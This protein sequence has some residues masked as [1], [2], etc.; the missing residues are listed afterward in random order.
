MITFYRII[1]QLSWKLPLLLLLYLAFQREHSFSSSYS[2]NSE[3][4]PTER[5][6]ISSDY[7]RNASTEKEQSHV[8]TEEELNKIVR[9][10]IS[11]GKG[12]KSNMSG[13]WN[14]SSHLNLADSFPS[15]ILPSTSIPLFEVPL[16]L[17]ERPLPQ[18][19]PHSVS[20]LEVLEFW[21]WQAI[22]IALYSIAA[23]ASLSMN[24][25]TISILLKSDRSITNELWKFLICL[26]VSD[27]GMSIFCIPTTYTQVMLQRWIFPNWLC[28][29]VSF[30]QLCFVFIS[31]WS[32]VLIGIDR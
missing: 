15:A 3:T 29:V 24:I 5:T 21:P 28:P 23:V 6:V 32:L 13:I 10:L 17:E 25:M 18:K 27:I 31:V 26:C 16:N 1:R 14:L 22:L 4:I 20:D 11:V 19:P 9:I 30:A 2:A 8:L 12:S 7:G